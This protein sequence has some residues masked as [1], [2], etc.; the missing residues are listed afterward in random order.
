VTVIESR[1]GLLRAELDGDVAPLLAALQ[2]IPVR[3][4]LIEPARLEEA[5]L[6]YYG[7]DAPDAPVAGGGHA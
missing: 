3:D 2:G 4:L 7:S 5:F 1:P 6:E